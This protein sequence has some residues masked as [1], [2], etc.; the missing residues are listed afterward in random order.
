M[1]PNSEQI[2]NCKNGFMSCC[3][4]NWYRSIWYL[5]IVIITICIMVGIDYGLKDTNKCLNTYWMFVQL[6]NPNGSYQYLC[7]QSE[8]KYSLPT[9]FILIFT[10]HGLFAICLFHFI[11]YVMIIKSKGNQNNNKKDDTNKKSYN[12][13]SPPISSNTIKKQTK[14]TKKKEREIN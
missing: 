5:L 1:A 6:F 3:K 7:Y 10:F 11:Q 2:E 12:Y 8:I 9:A 4:Y 13:H 14:K